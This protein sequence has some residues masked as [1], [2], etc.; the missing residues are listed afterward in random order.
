MSK[1]SNRTGGR[2]GDAPHVHTSADDAELGGA[3]ATLTQVRRDLD[4]ASSDSERLVTA[5]SHL[6]AAIDLLDDAAAP[7]LSASLRVA[8]KPVQAS[9]FDT[10]AMSEA[11]A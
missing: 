6:R 7:A 11:S 8:A 5:L 2:N 9:L 4:V 1:R 3:P 10:A